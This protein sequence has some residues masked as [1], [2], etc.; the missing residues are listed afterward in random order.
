MSLDLNLSLTKVKPPRKS[1]AKPKCIHLGTIAGCL[2]CRGNYNCIHRVRIKNCTEGCHTDDVCKHKNP[3][4]TCIACHGEGICP[5]PKAYKSWKDCPQCNVFDTCP[6]GKITRGC[7]ICK[8]LKPPCE[9]GNIDGGR[10]CGKCH[11]ELM[12]PCGKFY[13][14]NCMDC[15]SALRCEHDNLRT[16]CSRCTESLLCHHVDENNNRIPKRRCRQCNPDYRCS[17]GKIESHCPKCKPHISCE[18]NRITSGCADCNPKL[19]CSNEEHIAFSKH[20]KYCKMCDGQALCDNMDCLSLKI[21]RL[22]NVCRKCY[23]DSNPDSD[24]S[25]RRK[26][27]ENLVVK[28][29]KKY[30]PDD[31]WIVDTAI[32]GGSSNMRPDIFLRL[33]THCIII[34]VDEHGHRHKNYSAERES[35]R[36]LCLSKDVGGIPIKYIRFNPDSYDGNRSSFVFKES[37]LVIANEDEWKNRIDTLVSRIEV[38]KTEIPKSDTT[39]RLFFSKTKM[40]NSDDEE[41]D[42]E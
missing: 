37:G 21:K 42:S 38:A 29:I 20:K 10:L 17:C 25:I 15:N 33:P 16:G 2:V 30:F 4:E 23:C 36:G 27:K 41:S 8:A 26:T 39:E 19:T 7:K 22:G 35:V 13:K 12:C 18:H 32:R 9:H 40:V 5:H 28:C 11:K 6:H 14:N 34:E 24:L 1:Q 31:R 3:K